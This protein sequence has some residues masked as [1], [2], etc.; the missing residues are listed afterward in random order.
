[1]KKNE[2]VKAILD[3]GYDSTKSKLNQLTV[4]KLK[5]IYDGIED[6]K[7]KE[8]V[9]DDA[10]DIEALKEQIRK[11]AVEEAKQKLR[12]EMSAESNNESNEKKET[13]KK[14]QVDRDQLVDVMSVTEGVLVYR[15]KRSGQE[16][17]FNEYGA[18][19]TIDVAELMAMRSGQSKFLNEP[20]IIVLDDEVVE[21]LG[22]KKTYEK[23]DFVEDIDT[24]FN[25]KNEDF[26]ALLNKSPRGIQTTILSRAKKLVDNG[27]LDSTEKIR[28][29]E[30]NFKVDLT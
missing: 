30:E 23:I 11:E 22:L 14:V 8:E 21:F 10:L 25:K 13:K 17:E 24:I 18:I 9:K 15:S 5:E 29:M 2:L 28:F 3:S 6:A 20:F 26:K 7:P 19:D 27:E 1:M 12:E 16:W 4:S